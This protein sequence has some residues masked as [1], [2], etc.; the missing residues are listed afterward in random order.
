MSKA[1][2]QPN[3]IWFMCDQLHPRTLGYMGDPV[4]RTPNLDRLAEL[5]TVF[6]RMFVQNSVCMPS[7]AIMWTS[8]YL[9]NLNMANG[10]PVLDPHE[11]TLAEILQRAGYQTG[12]FGKLHLTPQVYTVETLQSDRPVS[13]AAAFCEAAGLGPAPADPVKRNYGFQETA[14][15]E[16]HC[17]LWGE[18]YEW[19]QERAPE[20]LEAAR[21]SYTGPNPD[22]GR[23]SGC[24]DVGI[25][26]LTADV[27]PSA[28]IADCA[29]E[30]FK[31]CCREEKPCLAHVS[32]VDP[33]HP[34]N[35]PRDIAPHYPVEQMPLP[36]H[37]D[38][39]ENVHW[40]PSLA[41]RMAPKQNYLCPTDPQKIQTV[42][43]YNYALL[44]TLDRAVG[45]VIEAVEQAGQMENTI[46]LF[47]SDH[48]EMLGNYGL[49]RKGSWH[50][51]CMIQT[52]CFLTAAGRIPAGGHMEELTETID[53]APTL[54]GL[55]GLDIPDRMQGRNLAPALLNHADMPEKPWI[56]CEMF[57]TLWGPWTACQTIRTRTAKLN[58]FP[59]DRVGHLFDLEN[60]PDERRNLWDFSEHRPLRDAMMANLL[61]ELNRQ[62]DGSPR[63]LSQY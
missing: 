36:A 52:P 5:G 61:E 7:R 6:D 24:H 19:L 55:A 44:E 33:H 43:A 14:H 12:L 37:R 32:F 15:F 42:T 30:F 48:G 57:Q 53:L 28:F 34:W 47:V 26:D 21:I 49:L 46:F 39:G 23:D 11:T 51:D 27:H 54:L 1:N 8:R 2:Q 58:Y 60:D 4:A 20:M 9:R 29:I 13:D 18:Y 63:V 10:C 45:R 38:P 62:I 16:D 56:Y 40:P 59:I 25:T 31:R 3:I 41:E 35:P 17:K 50:Y 22:F